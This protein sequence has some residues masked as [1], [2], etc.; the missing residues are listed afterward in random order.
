MAAMQPQGAVNQS[1]FDLEITVVEK[2]PVIAE[3][4]NDTSDNCGGSCQSACSN[5]TCE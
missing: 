1:D 2:A 3:L 4:M 5:S